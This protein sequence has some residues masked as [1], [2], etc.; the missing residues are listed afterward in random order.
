MAGDLFLTNSVRLADEWYGHLE[1]VREEM[2]AT[3]KRQKP[4]KV[5]ILD[6]GIDVSQ[7]EISKNLNKRI[8]KW[9]SFPELSGS[10]KDPNGHGTYLAC[11]FMRTVPNALLYI[12]R[13]FND[14]NKCTHSEVAK[15]YPS[16]ENSLIWVGN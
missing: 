6:T 16:P 8:V 1:K 5:A 7:S 9:Q 4:V 2:N 3:R 15:V 11:V 13:I 12:A 14:N 10:L